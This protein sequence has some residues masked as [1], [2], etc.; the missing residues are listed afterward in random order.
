M[1]SR[2]VWWWRQLLWLWCEEILPDC[3]DVVVRE[4]TRMSHVLLHTTI[5]LPQHFKECLHRL[6]PTRLI[7]KIEQ[8]GKTARAEMTAY[9]KQLLDLRQTMVR[10]QGVTK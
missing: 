3:D 4:A 6:F 7:S 10:V 9:Y 8:V 2:M 5:S 1:K